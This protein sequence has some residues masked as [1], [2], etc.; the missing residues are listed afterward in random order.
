MASAEF[1]AE[2][3]SG[4]PSLKYDHSRN[5]S[6]TQPSDS[7]GNL[8]ESLYYTN[9]L[10]EKNDKTFWIQVIEAPDILGEAN[11]W[12]SVKLISKAKVVK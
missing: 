9:T 8:E 1:S 4:F 6:M 2:F 10:K 11:V 3:Q 12:E 5:F 7:G